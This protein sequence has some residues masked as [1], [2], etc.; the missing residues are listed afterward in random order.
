MLRE[1]KAIKKLLLAVEKDPDTGLVPSQSAGRVKRTLDRAE[2]ELEGHLILGAQLL[3]ED[4]PP[5]G[6]GD[7]ATAVAEAGKTM[8]IIDALREKLC[9]PPSE[10]DQS[11]V[12]AGPLGASLAG[13]A[14]LKP[15]HVLRGMKIGGSETVVGVVNSHLL[16][17]ISFAPVGEYRGSTLLAQRSKDGYQDHPDL[18]ATRRLAETLA[19]DHLLGMIPVVLNGRGRWLW[20]PSPTDELE[21]LVLTYDAAAVIDGRV[22]IGAMGLAAA[23][24]DV[25]FEVPFVLFPNLDLSAEQRLHHELRKHGDREEPAVSPVR[26]P[27]QV[28]PPRL[29]VGV[30]QVAVEVT[31]EPYVVLGPYG[32]S[33]LVDVIA[34]ETGKRHGLF[35]S[36]KSLATQLE[37][38]R[39]PGGSLVGLRLSV[40]KEG[41]ER[42]AGY[43]VEPL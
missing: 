34:V 8:S 30:R 19:D 36:A 43:L 35:V 1:R 33:P 13:S 24:R 21:G 41:S 16:S 28:P 40:C 29:A 20:S 2:E 3:S 37:E 6:R 9:E 38:L 39:P 31:S 22:R 25:V 15:G 4:G 5:D 23:D 32:Y 11:V 26:R 18:L 12:R 42:T 27:S 17:Q 7:L 14:K 10:A